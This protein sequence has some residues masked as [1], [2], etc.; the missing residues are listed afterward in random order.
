MKRKILNCILY[1]GN[2]GQVYE[3][4]ERFKITANIFEISIKRVKKIWNKAVNNGD[5]IF[6]V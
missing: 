6:V 5:V 3:Q 1:L 4:K 2:Y